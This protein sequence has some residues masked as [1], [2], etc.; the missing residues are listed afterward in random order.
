MDQPYSRIADMMLDHQYWS[1]SDPQT[2]YDDTAW[3][4]GELGNVRVTRATDLKVL[5]VPME[6]V[7]AEIKAPGGI[8][9]SG[10]VFL[11]NH[12]ADNSLMTLCYR[13]K[14]VS[15]AVSEEPFEVSGRKF[16]RG[17]FIISGAS[18]ETLEN[19]ASALGLR[20]LAVPAIP[21]VKTHPV[22]AARI[23]LMHTWLST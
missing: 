8:Q 10:T 7:A 12:N 20:M 3:T 23:A 11:V 5:D 14:N 6:K 1:P 9:G 2:A 18:R 21:T 16:N 15:M 17:S 4:F 22:E 19:E 13:L